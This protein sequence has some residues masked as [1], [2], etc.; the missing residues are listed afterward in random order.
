MSAKQQQKKQV[1][2]ELVE[3]YKALA[4]EGVDLDAY[5]IETLGAIHD[6]LNRK[7]S[8]CYRSL[9]GAAVAVVPLGGAG[10]TLLTGRSHAKKCVEA[11]GLAGR[12]ADETVAKEVMDNLFKSMRIHSIVE[13]AIGTTIPGI[14]SV[15]AAISALKVMNS[16]LDVVHETADQMH[17][18]A[19]N[20]VR[21]MSN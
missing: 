11:Y 17:I 21:A 5:R 1:E 20:Q 19:I 8:K 3:Q 4:A 18:N 9:R 14:S 10:H 12:H 6:S 16:V 13:E 7:R 2:T 15:M